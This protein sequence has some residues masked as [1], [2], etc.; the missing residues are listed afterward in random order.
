MNKNIEI[1]DDGTGTG[2]GTGSHSICTSSTESRHCHTRSTTGTD[3][4]VHNL[5]PLP[6]AW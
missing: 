2:T 5:M 4:L 1:W 6:F 3:N